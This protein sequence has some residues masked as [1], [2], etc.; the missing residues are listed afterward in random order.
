MHCGRVRLKVCHTHTHT[1]TAAHTRAHTHT[2]YSHS[3]RDELL[4]LPEANAAICITTTEMCKN[5]LAFCT[6]NSSHRVTL[7][8]SY[9]TYTHCGGIQQLITALIKQT[10]TGRVRVRVRG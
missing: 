8:R 9:V 6:C 10:E 5:V 2:R 1:R 4:L 3:H 7:L